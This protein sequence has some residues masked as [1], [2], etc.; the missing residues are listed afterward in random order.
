[1]GLQTRLAEQEANISSLKQTLL[2]VTLAKQ[3]LES[4][5]KELVRRVEELDQE[6]EDRRQ[7]SRQGDKER[8][9]LYAEELRVARDAISNLRSSFSDADPGQHILDTLE[10]CIM[11]IVE[12]MAGEAGASKPGSSM[13]G[14]ESQHSESGLHDTSTINS[15]S[16]QTNVLLILRLTRCRHQDR[17]LHPS[18]C[19]PLHDEH[20]EARGQDHPQGLQG[21]V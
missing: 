4:E 9:G 5:K 11:C 15:V 1:M 13:S 3:S 8:A 7:E 14:R 12:R 21:S 19:D 20:H 18:L 6:Q 2:R 16:P 17:V 10:Q